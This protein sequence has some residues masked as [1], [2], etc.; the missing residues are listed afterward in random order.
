MVSVAEP[1]PVRLL[2]RAKNMLSLA[3]KQIERAQRES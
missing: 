2:L 1:R 3:N